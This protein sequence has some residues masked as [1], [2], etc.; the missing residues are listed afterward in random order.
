MQ[1]IVCHGPEDY[2]LQEVATPQPAA[3]EAVLRVRAVGICASDAKCWSG[4][5]LFWGD[6]DRPAYCQAPVIPGHEF[7]G[8]VVALGH[9]VTDLHAGDRVVAEQIIPC[10]QCR[11]CR[12]G[13]YWMCQ[14]HDIFGFRQAAPGAMAQYVKL[15]AASIRYRLPDALSAEAGAFVE[16]LGCSIHAVDRA[17]IHLGDVVVIA[18]CGPLGLGM[19]AAA[20]L[21]GPSQLIALDTRD[22]RRALAISCGADLAL[23]PGAD[24]LAQVLEW[25]DGYGCDVYIE[26]SG[27]PDA[28]MQG[29]QMVRKLGT[30]VEF[31]VMR[32]PSTVDWTIIGDTKE[33]TIKGSHL[34]PHTYPVAIDML[35]R[36]LLPL[37][38]I[39]TH[40]LPLTAFAEGM[41]LVVDG[42]SSV[43]VQLI[44]AD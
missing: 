37:G 8:E 42:R 7:A 2:R 11:Y 33:L 44:P 16:P 18:G 32:Q 38:Q 28:V 20:R 3:G 4:A 30:F 35:C 27:A 23:E 10:G 31:S 40:R 9:G 14:R 21:R 39:I 26:A 15:P 6:A 19:V 43:K 36:G 17:D 22:T 1:A 13:Q 5:P 12:H 25:T 41:A 34:S 29:L 24:A